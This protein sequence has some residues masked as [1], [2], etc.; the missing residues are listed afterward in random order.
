MNKVILRYSY[1]IVTGNLEKAVNVIRKS[2]WKKFAA[3]PE[4]STKIKIDC[5]IAG[6]RIHNLMMNDK[7]WEEIL[8]LASPP[9]APGSS[10]KSASAQSKASD[11][12]TSSSNAD[13]GQKVQK[14]L[15]SW[16]QIYKILPTASDTDLEALQSLLDDFGQ[17]YID[18]FGDLI[19]PYIHIL[20]CHTV[21]L[22]RNH[23]PLGR[24]EQQGLENS[25]NIHKGSL[26][27]V[28]PID[29]EG[30]NP[31]QFQL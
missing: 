4:T 2:G 14:L 27:R 6:A 15:G 19:T 25:I 21:Q 18:V 5:F 9:T 12:D 10:A 22:I 17:S 7:A 24:Y 30:K 1:L 31:H 23:G 13:F 16:R 8:K 28:L 11:I 3:H 29:L 20:V 26:F